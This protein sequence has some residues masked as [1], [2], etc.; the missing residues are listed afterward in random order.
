MFRDGHLGDSDLIFAV[1]VYFLTVVSFIPKHTLD[2]FVF[3]FLL[4]FYQMSAYVL[5]AYSLNQ[6]PY[7]CGVDELAFLAA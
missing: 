5:L 4:A 1:D 7:S 2:L 3:Q 6:A